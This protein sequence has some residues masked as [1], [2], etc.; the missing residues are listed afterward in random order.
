MKD[1]KE[2]NRKWASHE[3]IVFPRLAWKV[4]RMPNPGSYP[5]LLPLQFL[6]RSKFGICNHSLR[7]LEADHIFRAT[8]DLNRTS[9]S[10]AVI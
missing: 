2:G 10:R 6:S 5:R 8:L 9:L 7:C 1:I 3:L 4:F